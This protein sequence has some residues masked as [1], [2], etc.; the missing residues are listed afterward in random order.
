MWETNPTARYE[1]VS[2]SVS[3]DHFYLEARIE[4][5]TG[6][7][8]RASTSSMSTVARFAEFGSTPICRLGMAWLSTTSLPETPPGRNVG[9]AVLP[10]GRSIGGNTAILSLR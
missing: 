5:Q 4:L 2:T 3:D 1:V 9:P 7:C 8:C 10:G 6:R